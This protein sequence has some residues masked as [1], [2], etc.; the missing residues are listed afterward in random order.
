MQAP[1]GDARVRTRKCMEFTRSGAIC[2]SGITSLLGE[3]LQQRE[4]INQLTAYIDASQVYGSSVPE[5]LSLQSQ[6]ERKFLRK[7]IYMLP[8]KPLMPFATDETPVDCRRNLRE[9]DVGCFLGGDIRANEQMGLLAMHTVW[10]RQH[11]FLAGEL[12]RLNPSW[13]D[14]VVFQEARKII[15]AQMQHVTYDHWLPHVI[16]EK[17]MEELG[18][19]HGY[20]PTGTKSETKSETIKSRVAP[21]HF[22][23]HLNFVAN[24]LYFCRIQTGLGVLTKEYEFPLKNCRFKFNVE[25]VC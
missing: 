10:F 6:T 7:G 13:L 2:G 1:E 21:E 17:G 19:Y 14:E 25:I 23:N 16:G 15:G 4:Q 12:K 11:N 3:A 24:L 18:T 20:D 8:N 22:S 5:L 9:S